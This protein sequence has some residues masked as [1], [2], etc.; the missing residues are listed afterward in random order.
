MPH[1]PRSDA[2]GGGP[3]ATTRPRGPRSR[4]PRPVPPRP[5]ATPCCPCC[6]GGGQDRCR[7]ARRRSRPARGGARLLRTP[8]TAGGRCHPRRGARRSAAAARGD[9]R[10]R[11][12]RAAAAPCAAWWAP[13]AR[14][15]DRTVCPV[16]VTAEYGGVPDP[17]ALLET[18]R[19]VRREGGDPRLLVLSVA[20]DPTATVPPPEAVHE[21]VGGRCGGRP[22]PGE[23]RV[24]AGHPA[25]PAAHRRTAPGRARG[26]AMP[27]SRPGQGTG[28]VVFGTGACREGRSGGP[29]ALQGVASAAHGACCRAACGVCGRMEA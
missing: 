16:L 14:M 26:P 29:E 9:R 20:D 10:T 15:L 4:P 11:R 5:G 28:Q 27:V 2:P 23:R 25:S 13:Q 8:W 6:R 1:V 19:R 21:T 24:A 17:C 7:A 18:V 3:D 12:G 22:A